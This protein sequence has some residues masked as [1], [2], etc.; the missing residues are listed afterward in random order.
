M[1]PGTPTPPDSPRIAV[2]TAN[3]GGKDQLRDPA[4]LASR[5]DYIAFSDRPFSSDVWQ[6]RQA[7]IW[8]CDA[9]FAARRSARAVKLLLTNLLPEYEYT[10]WQDANMTLLVEP[11]ELVRRY[12]TDPLASLA[13]HRHSPRDCVYD[14]AR[15]ILAIKLDSPGPVRA[16]MR[17]Y[18]T[19][20]YPRHA[21]LFST[22]F[23]IRRNLP[24][25]RSLEMA[26]WEQLC[27][28]SSRDQ[29]SLPFVIHR[30]GTRIQSIPDGDTWKN[31]LFQLHSHEF[32]DARQ[33]PWRR[34]ARR[35]LGRRGQ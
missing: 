31:D 34:W 13:A 35:L 9:K 26:W 5:V 11:Q 2:V 33:P 29:L 23:L 4:I 28:F 6:Y 32:E 7:S 18:R 10:I 14:E 19:L 27:R 3:F 20:G 21:G 16:Q 30:L 8:S 12:L 17:F 22:R 1:T 15:Q 24:A 25:T